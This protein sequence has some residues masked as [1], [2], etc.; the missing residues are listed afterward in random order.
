[1]FYLPQCCFWFGDFPSSQSQKQ[2]GVRRVG[3]SFFDFCLFTGG[4]AVCFLVFSVSGSIDKPPTA[5]WRCNL[6]LLTSLS[7]SVISFII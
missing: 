7:R 5:C 3:A 1:M 2:L 6:A 4:G